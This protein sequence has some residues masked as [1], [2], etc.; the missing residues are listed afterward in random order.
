MANYEGPIFDADNHFYEAHD[1]F[2][3]H[4]PKEMQARCVQWVELER[5]GRQYQLVGG[6]MDPEGTNGNPTFDP[7]SKP[8]V[9][10]E[11]FQGNPDGRT[12]MELIRSSLEP[13]R[14]EYMDREARLAVMDEQGL[15]G[16]WIF[17]TQAVLMEQQIQHDTGA[18]LVMFDAFNK[19]VSEDWGF[20]FK[21]RIFTAPYI[22]L[23][24]VDW[25]CD[26]L[27]KALEQDARLVVMRP[28]AVFTRQGPRNPGDPMFDPFWARVNEAG[29]TVAIHI[30]S[31]KHD[32]NGY[33]R[34][35][36]DM[37]ALG[38]R[39]T[40]ANFHRSRNINDFLASLVFDL[41][42]ERF[43]NLRIVSVENGSEFL[44]GLLRALGKSKHRTP[45]HYTDDPV[46]S[47]REHVWINPFWEDDM[48]EIIELMGADHVT[49]GSDWPHM[50]GMEHPRDILSELDGISEAD[51]RLVLHDNAAALNTPRPA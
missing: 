2:T 1:A 28:S 3:R 44:P 14:P 40:I 27:D 21:D 26:Q 30:G 38:P 10:R 39:P 50:E 16:A 18:A 24:D 13:L 8:G 15:D 34:R 4:V 23:A 7:I 22:T 43:P 35:S 6:R 11:L 42:F 41:L 20:N 48:V 5:N 36:H 46:D 19:W 49:Y 33:D 25:A 51:Q 32:N 47:F 45:K 12:G 17:P 37:L 29:I 31:T 9:L